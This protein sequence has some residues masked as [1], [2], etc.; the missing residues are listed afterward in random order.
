MKRTKIQKVKH[1]Y[2]DVNKNEVNFRGKNTPADIEYENNKQKNANS[3]Y[4]K[5]RHLTAT[6]NGLDDK[7]QINNWKHPSTGQ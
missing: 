4:R 5:K 2:R 7:V 3:D 6:R 1:R